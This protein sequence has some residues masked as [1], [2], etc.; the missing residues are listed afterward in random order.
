MRVGWQLVQHGAEQPRRRHQP[1]A[2]Q[3]LLARHRAL[4]R[5]ARA[6]HFS[7]ERQSSQRFGAQPESNPR[8]AHIVIELTRAVQSRTGRARGRKRTGVR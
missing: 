2:Q 3:A 8:V 1:R 6:L 7:F 4:L 5:P